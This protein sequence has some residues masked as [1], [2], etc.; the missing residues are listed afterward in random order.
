MQYNSHATNQDCVSE[1]LKICG[2]TTA[3][4]PI[5]DLTRRFNAAL[6]RYLQLAYESDSQ[7]PFDDVNQSTAAIVTQNIVSGTNAY[8]Q[9]SFSGTPLNL[10][11]LIAVNSAGTSVV[12]TEENFHDVD[13]ETDYVNAASAATVS[14][15][16]KY[17]DFYYLRPKPSYNATNGLR[18]FVERG[19]VYMAATDTTRVPGTDARHHMFL[20]RYTALPYL[21]ENKLPQTQAV[22]QQILVDE[23]QVRNDLARRGKDVDPRFIPFKEDNR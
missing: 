10:L 22:S 3:S 16:T 4:Y 13:F 1:V 6:D 17:G 11:K 20:C 23:R 12:L 5:N 21:I 8:K 7:W 19:A 14:Y 2:A 18:A 15:Y 9:G